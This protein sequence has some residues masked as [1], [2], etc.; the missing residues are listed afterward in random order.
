[1]SYHLGQYTKVKQQNLQKFKSLIEQKKHDTFAL[2]PFPKLTQTAKLAIVV[3]SRQQS[4]EFFLYKPSVVQ[5]VIQFFCDPCTPLS[6]FQVK[7]ERVSIQRAP[8]PDDIVWENSKISIPGAIFR[9]SIFNLLGALVL[10][11]GGAAQYGLAILQ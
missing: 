4:K 8:E 2:T 10:F 7:A 11:A 6:N 5:K 3:F 9:K 1:M